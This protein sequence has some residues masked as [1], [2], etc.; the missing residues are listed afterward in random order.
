MKKLFTLFAMAAPFFSFAQHY[1]S[2]FEDG[3]KIDYD[4][5]SDK[6][7]DSKRINVFFHEWSG[8]AEEIGMGLGASYH[9]PDK[10]FAEATYGFYPASSISFDGIYF[11]KSWD[12]MKKTSMSVKSEYVGNN[13][14]KK[15]II[16]Y[17][18]PRRCHIGP[19]VGYE[20]ISFRSTA[21]M[22]GASQI[23]IGFGFFRGR[24]LN[25]VIGDK[26]PIKRRGTSQFGAYADLVIASV[27]YSSDYTGTKAG[28]TGFRAYIQGKTSFVGSRDW[29]LVYKFG[30]G[31]GGITPFYEIIDLGLYAG[32]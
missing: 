5:I 32:F 22:T 3:V 14:I 17:E 4:I 1:T 20:T 21:E 24:F 11:L 30:L 15:Y 13:T 23:Y 19:H 7:N 10:F 16:K 27:N 12:K 2:T 31:M 6:F 29:G 26:K 18:I 28:G 8:N 9:L 25:M